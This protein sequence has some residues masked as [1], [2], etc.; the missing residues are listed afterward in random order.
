MT[1]NLATLPGVRLR[2][3]AWADDEHRLNLSLLHRPELAAGPA[4]RWTIERLAAHC[5]EHLGGARS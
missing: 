2:P 3:A 1:S 5:Q 4:T